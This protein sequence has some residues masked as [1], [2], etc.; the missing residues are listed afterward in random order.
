MAKGRANYDRRTAIDKALAVLEAVADQPQ[1]VGLPDLSVRLALPRQTVH[2]ILLQLE[3]EGLLQRDIGRDRFAIGPRFSA[4]ALRALQTR[5]QS[6]PVRAILQGLVDDVA[7]TCNIGVLD[8]LDFL[9]LE[10]IECAW[11]LRVHLQTG[12][13]LP[14]HA[15]SGG[16]VMLAYLD[17]D[18]R[19]RLLRSR[20][21]KAYTPSTRIRVG[22]LEEEFAR[23]RAQGYAFN[24]QEFALGIV[25]VAVPVLSA[26]G[27]AP[28]ALA[29]HGPAARLDGKRAIS[30]VPRLRE[31][32]AA[33][34]RAWGLDRPRSSS[35]RSSPD[36]Q[37]A[38]RPRLARGAL[39]RDELS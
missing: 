34:A 3:A 7:E 31:G 16:K 21:L 23:I 29:L 35:V 5:N 38:Q 1:P 2:R 10:R 8:G 14:A 18:L 13:R 26:G 32:A 11:S 4:L 28:A 17:D 9:Y 36:I 24:D 39:S 33:L 30:L 12:S 25:G 22:E 27:A 20:K 19:R 37:K 15:T 6:A